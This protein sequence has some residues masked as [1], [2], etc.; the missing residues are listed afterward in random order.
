MENNKVEIKQLPEKNV[1]VVT[2][3]GNYMGNAEVFKGLFDKLIGWAA[4]QG[5]MGP[6]ASFIASYQDDP[7]TIPPDELVLDLCMTISE[8]TECEGDVVNK[9]LA[10][11]EYAVMQAELAGPEEY[12]P[13][14][15]EVVKWME[16]NNYVVDMSRPSYEIYLNNP[17]DHPEKHHILEICMSVK[18][19]E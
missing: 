17:E 14:W 1:A 18:T 19:K 13:A 12:G 4:P 5:L 11:G 2:F 10:G 15:G 16:E 6:E 8:G 3:V 7:K 9:T